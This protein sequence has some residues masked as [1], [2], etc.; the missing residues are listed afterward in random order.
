MFLHFLF[1]DLSPQP[2]L[3]LWDPYLEHNNVL[4]FFKIVDL[5]ISQLS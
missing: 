5:S 4:S 1:Y 3:K 2:R